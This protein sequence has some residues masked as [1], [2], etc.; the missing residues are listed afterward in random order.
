MFSGGVIFVVVSLVVFF[1]LLSLP[2]DLIS[3]SVALLSS[4]MACFMLTFSYMNRA[5]RT[6]AADAFVISRVLLLHVCSSPFE[7]S[8]D[9]SN[10]LLLATF[11]SIRL[12]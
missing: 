5:S 9:S 1:S 7:E 12:S 4:Y 10:L 3:F 8:L 11:E 2:D 6:D